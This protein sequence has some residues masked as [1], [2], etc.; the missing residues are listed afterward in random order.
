MG[1]GHWLA[2]DLYGLLASDA[3]TTGHI[4]GYERVFQPNNQLY[5]N[6]PQVVFTTTDGRT[7][8]LQDHAGSG[9]AT[10]SR[11]SGEPVSVIYNPQMPEQTMIQRGLWNW[12]TPFGLLALG[13]LL[14][15]TTV[16]VWTSRRHLSS[17]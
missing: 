15:L 10:T 7:I 13:L 6:Y 12:A 5:I 17:A 3:S 11:S 14:L 4:V 9:A 1:T 8:R 2:K 16:K